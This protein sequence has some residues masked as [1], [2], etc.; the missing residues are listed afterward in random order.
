MA[1]RRAISSNGD[2]LLLPELAAVRVTIYNSLGQKIRDLLQN[3]VKNAGEH[4][5]GWDGR[6]DAGEPIRRGIYFYRLEAGMTV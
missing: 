6:N 2:S 3:E 1:A 4:F 5:L